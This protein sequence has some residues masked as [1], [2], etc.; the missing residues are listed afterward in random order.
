MSAPVRCLKKW[1]IK[2]IPALPKLLSRNLASH[3]KHSSKIIW[4]PSTKKWTFRLKGA[5]TN[6]LPLTNKNKVMSNETIKL[7]AVIQSFIQATNQHDGAAYIN[8]FADD[9]LVNDVARNFWG[10]DAIKHWCDK[11]IID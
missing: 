6:C 4:P 11:E 3:P 10:T 1:V 9:A 8:T 2:I 7:P 5:R